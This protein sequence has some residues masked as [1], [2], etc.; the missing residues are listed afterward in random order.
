MGKTADL[1]ERA[2]HELTD[3]DLRSAGLKK[4]AKVIL[5]KD[6]GNE[7]LMKVRMSDWDNSHLSNDQ[8]LYACLDAYLAFAIGRQLESWYD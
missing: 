7:E 2:A 1:R 5:G 6:V 8:V 3:A 4:L